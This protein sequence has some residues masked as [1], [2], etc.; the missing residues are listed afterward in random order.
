MP[1]TWNL[2]PAG[3]R[4]LSVVSWKLG[5]TLTLIGA[6]S[7]RGRVAS[8]AKVA[9]TFPLAGSTPLVVHVP[10]RPAV[11]V[12]TCTKVMVPARAYST[13]SGAPAGLDPSAKRRTPDT[14]VGLAPCC[15]AAVTVI[16]LG[17]GAERGGRGRGAGSWGGRGA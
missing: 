4:R 14:L 17:G 7:S 10:S 3:A 12:V 11:V 15:E 13:A 1:V 6:D 9:R 8:P 16:A 2:V 5:T